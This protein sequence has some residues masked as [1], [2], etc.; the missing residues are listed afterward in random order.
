[1]MTPPK[2][3]GSRGGVGDWKEEK[4]VDGRVNGQVGVGVCLA[5]GVPAEEYHTEGGHGAA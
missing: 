4:S 2:D 3:D 1:M 5:R